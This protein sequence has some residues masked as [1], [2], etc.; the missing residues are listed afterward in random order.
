[1]PNPEEI[2]AILNGELE[3]ETSTFHEH[4]KGGRVSDDDFRDIVEVER[5]L[6]KMYKKVNR[7]AERR[8][9]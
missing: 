3:I 6:V 2:K 4:V 7:R 9:G 1:M 8:G 5:P